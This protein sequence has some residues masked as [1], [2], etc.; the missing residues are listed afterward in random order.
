MKDSRRSVF[1]IQIA[2]FILKVVFKKPI[3][4]ILLVNKVDILFKYYSNFITS[5]RSANYVIEVTDRNFIKTVSHR[6][7]YYMHYLRTEKSRLI[8]YYDC[9][10]FHL[11]FRYALQKLLSDNYGFFLHASAIAQGSHASLF[12]GKSSSGKSSV[13][14]LLRDK[15]SVLADDSMIVRSSRKSILLYQ[16]PFLEKESWIQQSKKRYFLRNIFLLKK[17][18]ICKIEKIDT[19]TALSELMANITLQDKI[20]TRLFKELSLFAS[21]HVFYYLFLNRNKHEVTR[22]VQSFY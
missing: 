1:F 8:T 19:S 3:E 22:L 15:F 4:N 16:A 9:L 2:D 18:Y 13:I 17:N 14:K 20:D 6:N 7:E 11:V 5:E 12:L 10:N 21:Q